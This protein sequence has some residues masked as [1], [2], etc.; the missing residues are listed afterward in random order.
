[1]SID[2]TPLKDARRVLFSVQLKP[3]QGTRFQPT[4]FPDLGAAVYQAG[5]TTYLLVESPQSMAN[6][7][8]AVCWDDAV[9]ELRKPLGGLSYVRVE[10]GGQYLTSSITEAHRLNSVYIEKANG[11]E[12]HRSFASEM[13][14]D[15]R[16]PINRNKFLAALLKYDV[17]SLIHG[18]FLESISGRLRVPRALSAFIEAEGVQVAA[19]GGVKK[20]HV[21]PGTTRDQNRASKE[22]YGNIIYAREEYTAERIIAYFNLDLGQ[23][24]S[25][26]LG[27]SVERLLVLLSL[28]KIRAF[29]DGDLRL[30]TACDLTVSNRGTPIIADPPPE[31]EL[32]TL[33]A[34][35][36]EVRRSITACR[37]R[38]AGVT[39]IAIG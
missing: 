28:Y 34:L 31:F 14:Y 13:E 9:N 10:R 2:L 27:E 5:E 24:H 1:M 12:F 6:R 17:N 38:M 26:G 8:E 35:E 15:E 33:P 23:I 30:R 29:L 7:L 25:Y 20:D 32:P 21:Q 39:R 19:S 16:A 4:G 3:V 22:G 18:V 36:D 11:G 37:E